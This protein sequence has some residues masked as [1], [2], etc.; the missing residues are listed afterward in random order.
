MHKLN[1]GKI[2]VFPKDNTLLASK[3]LSEIIPWY[4]V[5]YTHRKHSDSSVGSTN[6]KYKAIKPSSKNYNVFYIT[7]NLSARRFG[8]WCAWDSCFVSHTN[9]PI[10]QAKHSWF[11]L[12]TELVDIVIV[13]YSFI[14]KN[15]L[16]FIRLHLY[17][18]L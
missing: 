5:W 2:F 4:P 8:K 14:V 10:F 6:M 15:A 12:Q 3:Q 13:V 18:W 11:L 16:L 7:V 9:F 1:L 17:T